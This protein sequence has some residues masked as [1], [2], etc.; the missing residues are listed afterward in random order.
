MY[1][2]QGIPLGFRVAV[3]RVLGLGT[4]SS[5]AHETRHIT[6]RAARTAGVLRQQN[7]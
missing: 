5:R 6:S 7:L 4:N 2:I 3:H 1:G